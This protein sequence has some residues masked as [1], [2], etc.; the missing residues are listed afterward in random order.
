MR[1]VALFGAGKI[2]RMIAAFLSASGDY[3]LVVADLD[4]Q[5]LARVAG[6]QR[7]TTMQVDV[8][9]RNAVERVL[10]GRRCVIS[11]LSYRFCVPLAEAAAALEVSYFDLSEDVE[12]TRGIR[13]IAQGAKQGGTFMPQCGLAPGFVAILAQHLTKAFDRLD[14]VHMRVGALPQFPSNALRYN[15]TWS[16]DGLINEYC[17]PCEAILDGRRTELRPLEGLEHFWLNGVQYEAFNTSGGIGTL[18]ESLDGRLRDLNYKTIRYPGHRELMSF[19][20]EDL[21]LGE[22]R[23][24]LKDVLERAV[25][26]TFQDMVVVFCTASGWRSGQLVQISD[27]RI[28]YSQE[29]YGEAWSAIQISTAAALCA[30]LDLKLEGKLRD[31]G[32]VRQEEIALED[33]LANRFGR[34]YAEPAR[35]V[36]Q[37]P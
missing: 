32:F 31:S 25:P 28:V 20:I 3:E 34:Y 5:R 29:L 10:R 35:L 11:A 22:R 17:N 36:E 30:A 21:R 24:L 23:D 6:R 8:T 9:D 33:F 1:S 14:T 15:L 19:L 7:V 2:G 26:V 4:A 12:T 16:T 18:C 27:A 37:R 13:G